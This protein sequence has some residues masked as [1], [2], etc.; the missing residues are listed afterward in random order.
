MKCYLRQN[1]TRL[2]SRS[3]SDFTE[4]NNKNNKIKF[5]KI[6]VSFIELY[7]LYRVIFPRRSYHFAHS[8]YTFLF[9]NRR[10]TLGERAAVFLA[11]LGSDL[12]PNDTRLF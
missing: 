11:A 1:W 10:G 4:I 3:H 2:N 7:S 9:L 8:L 6:Q 12:A 5:N